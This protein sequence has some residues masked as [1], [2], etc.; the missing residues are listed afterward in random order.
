M[1][2]ASEIPTPFGVFLDQII[3]DIQRSIFIEALICQPIKQHIN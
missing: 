3:N 1:H 2:F